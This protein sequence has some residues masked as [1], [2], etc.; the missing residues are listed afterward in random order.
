MAVREA[1]RPG[2]RLSHGEH[3]R[4][5]PAKPTCPVINGE[6]DRALATKFK[7]L[8]AD[9]IA[10]ALE[11][12]EVL[13]EW[14]NDLRRLAHEML[15]AGHPVPGWKLVPK[16]AMRQWTDEKK[17]A[18]VLMDQ[19]GLKKEDLYD[20]EMK[21]PAQV[22]KLLKQQKMP[23]PEGI[24]TAVSSGSTLA[25]ESD[26]RPAVLQIGRQMVAALSKIQ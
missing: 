14:I 9:K 23:L 5:C 10:R 22:E 13:S 7:A 26:P 20:S 4:F 16:R 24:V 1:E 11:D 2:A 19:A 21:S 17:A 25:P 8:D 12:A 18:S 3:C 6:V 15:E